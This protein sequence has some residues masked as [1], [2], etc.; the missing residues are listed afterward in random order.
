MT[1][2]PFENRT[3]LLTGASRG[4]GAELSRQLRD[5]GAQVIGVARRRIEKAP[6]LVPVAL[7][8]AE[9]GAATELARRI[10]RD[11]P[12]CSGLIANAAIMVHTDLTRG[13]HAAEIAREIAVNLTAPA[14]LAAALLPTLAQNGPAFVNLVTS[15]LAI[16]P[17]AEAAVYCATKAGLRSF[18]RTLRY[19][20]EDAALPVHVS[21]TVMT[22]V[23]TDLSRALPNR[24]P[25]AEA[26][27]DLLAG[28]E[29]R[30]DEIW[31]GRTRLLRLVHRLS[32]ALA[33]RILRGENTRALNPADPGFA[34]RQASAEPDSAA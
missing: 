34:G 11:H 5:A 26:A 10:A 17:R 6:G 12:D 31:I 9:P 23:A 18:A 7:D 2:H 16:A 30:R 1:T 27:A 21:E 20:C 15:G 28:I 25:P 14:Q 32:P 19:Q 3:I 24:Y 33:F 13:D 8:L 22:L 29:D 4:I